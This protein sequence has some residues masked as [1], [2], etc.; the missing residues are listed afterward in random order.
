[1]GGADSSA[2]QEEPMPPTTSRRPSDVSDVVDVD[3]H[4]HQHDDGDAGAAPSGRPS[5][6]ISVPAHYIKT[7]SLAVTASRMRARRESSEVYGDGGEMLSQ[8]PRKQ[9]RTGMGSKVS[10]SS[11]PGSSVEHTPSAQAPDS[12]I[13]AD[14]VA[15]AFAAGQDLDMDAAI[16]LDY[17]GQTASVRK[18]TVP[19]SRAAGHGG[20]DASNHQSISSNTRT[21]NI[22]IP[23]SAA[24]AK[25]A[26]S[27]P[28]NH[29]PAT[30][31]KSHPLSD[32]GD[33]IRSE[34]PSEV[35]PPN[36]KYPF[37]HERA[38]ILDDAQPI[39]SASAPRYRHAGLNPVRARG[40]AN[41]ATSLGRVKS[42]NGELGSFD[43]AVAVHSGGLTGIAGNDVASSV[44]N[45]VHIATIAEERAKPYP[46]EIGRGE[47]AERIFDE[48]PPAGS[49]RSRAR[50]LSANTNGSIRNRNVVDATP[51]HDASYM[52]TTATRTAA[53]AAPAPANAL[54]GAGP[55]SAAPL[56]A[57]ERK[58]R[59]IPSSGTSFHM[60]TRNRSSPGNLVASQSSPPP[61]ASPLQ[62]PHET[63]YP[64]V[65]PPPVAAGNM[66]IIAA[67][68]QMMTRASTRGR[69]G[70]ETLV[71]FA[72]MNGTRAGSSSSSP[73]G[74]ISAGHDA[75][76][77]ITLKTASVTPGRESHRR[78]SR[79]HAVQP[80][81]RTYH[82]RTL[83]REVDDDSISL[84]QG[85]S[86]NSSPTHI[87]IPKL[88]DALSESI[89]RAM[90]TGDVR[91]VES[92][93]YIQDHAT[94]E[95]GYVGIVDNALYS[96]EGSKDMRVFRKVVRRVMRRVSKSATPGTSNAARA[97]S[98][99][100]RVDEP[101][102]LE[103]SFSD[104]APAAATEIP[105]Y[106]NPPSPVRRRGRRRDRQTADRKPV[107]VVDPSLSESGGGQHTATTTKTMTIS[108]RRTRRTTTPPPAS[109]EI[110]RTQSTAS[111]H[112]S[113]S[114]LSTAK[115]VD[116]AAEAL[117]STDGD[118]LAA[119]TATAPA[120]ESVAVSTATTNTAS[121]AAGTADTTFAPATVG[122]KVAQRSA[123]KR[124]P[125]RYQKPYAKGVNGE[126]LRGP[127]LSAA[128]Q[129]KYAEASKLDNPEK[130]RELM[131]ELP[132]VDVGVSHLR[133]PA[134]GTKPV[135]E[136]EEGPGARRKARLDAELAVGL[137]RSRYSRRR[138][139]E[140]EMEEAEL[141]EIQSPVDITSSEE[142]DDVGDEDGVD[143]TVASEAGAGELKVPSRAAA[144]R[145]R[146]SS[147]ALAKTRLRRNQRPTPTQGLGFAGS[148]SG[149]KAKKKVPPSA[150]SPGVSTRRVTRASAPASARPSSEP[151][152]PEV[153]ALEAVGPVP[154]SS[155]PEG[156]QI[157]DDYCYQCGGS[158]EL[159]CCDGCVHSFHFTCLDPPIDPE[160]PPEGRW[161][162]V[163]CDEKYEA[164][165]LAK[166]AARSRANAGAAPT[167]NEGVM[168]SLLDNAETIPP[169]TFQLP[170]ALRNYY[171]GN[172]TGEHGEYAPAAV[173]PKKDQRRWAKTYAS[174]ERSNAHLYAL[175]DN[176][177]K[178][179]FCVACGR[180]SGG[181]RP[182]QICSYCP[183]AWHLDCLPF[184][185]VNPPFQ[186]PNSEKPYHHWKCPNHIDHDLRHIKSV[187][188][189]LGNF[190]RPRNPRW[191]D[192]DVIPS[193]KDFSAG[194]VGGHP[195]YY[196]EEDRDGVV[197]RVH[198]KALIMNFVERVK[199]ENLMNAALKNYYRA[200]VDKESPESRRIQLENAPQDLL[201]KVVLESEK[202]AAQR[203]T[204]RSGVHT[205][206]RSEPVS[207]AA[208][209]ISQLSDNY[210][211]YMASEQDAALGLLAM[212]NDDTPG[213]I[214][215]KDS[216][217]ARQ[218][219]AED[220]A[221]KKLS[222][223]LEEL[224]NISAA[225]RSGPESEAAQPTCTKQPSRFDSSFIQ[226]GRP[227][228]AA[229]ETIRPSSS[230]S[231]AAADNGD[232][233]LSRLRQRV[234]REP[235]QQEQS[236]SPPASIK[237]REMKKRA[238]E[239]FAVSD[240][241]DSKRSE[242]KL[243]QSIQACIAER[244]RVLNAEKEA[245]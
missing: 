97:I 165:E 132:Q 87:P 179:I 187:G 152:I 129:E 56:A 80:S 66:N 91:L 127:V 137:K 73:R 99:T 23:A 94:I 96:G 48:Q 172:K 191:I 8:Y 125:Q 22:D 210:L 110:M 155:D 98:T 50:R 186:R 176:K 1:M 3:H 218:E 156:S 6:S 135:K 4:N 71:S 111:D 19:P 24:P 184:P 90:E 207:V 227:S 209:G 106:T 183:S 121:A 26:Q 61:S 60:Q 167:S 39:S 84:N 185:V 30:Q 160:N 205:R 37:I 62:P 192:I 214:G 2:P 44:S 43:A 206:S 196:D 27:L 112:S 163:E 181:N 118:K 109:S 232:D 57:R 194:P 236:T 103:P 53:A 52:S 70:Y 144:A 178:F 102:V 72:Q 46:D 101:A 170:A 95:F 203:G 9:R 224:I 161:F 79:T 40:F 41:F 116:L 162:C 151:A 128:Q 153:S 42:G 182:I 28:F 223:L 104:S 201:A 202:E 211:L 58:A 113:T 174:D 244:M 171:A 226:F 188:G 225:D 139:I 59:D 166:A 29:P 243:L 75:R 31:L 215:A 208:A 14:T 150:A 93:R 190:K 240:Q 219:P 32:N 159:L 11:E 92:L 18:A 147:K 148:S 134:R 122:R 239:E 88:L 83:E 133:T 177:G 21:N 241:I 168:S 204:R 200:L 242:L 195:S 117:T 213:V 149:M 100:A 108:T 64:Y 78:Y 142:E 76:G 230:G 235:M 107:T 12:G 67:T 34:P 33:S 143:S 222:G 197:Y 130:R 126:N 10:V 105:D 81:S 120:V 54:G 86:V 82:D 169:S 123:K 16:M 234:R 136:T 212:K 228:K 245:I 158:G 55:S 124:K 47:D 193:N 146:E 140:L 131:Q 17:D 180:A 69:P 38:S 74:S 36:Q 115:S 7:P 189:R 20:E 198:E 233:K 154:D 25:R 237:E 13:D 157:N 199:Q 173:L 141:D 229:Q 68:P 51:E 114:S 145:A 89:R 220:V 77:Q 65:P 238:H 217:E 221:M 231:A 49:T 15:T 164:Q 138:Q 175:T 45:E 5:S 35:P 119:T 85:S 216:D 63:I